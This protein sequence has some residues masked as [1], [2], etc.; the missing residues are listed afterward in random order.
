[1]NPFVS[2]AKSDYRESVRQQ[3]AL[4]TLIMGRKEFSICL[5][6]LPRDISEEAS[7]AMIIDFELRG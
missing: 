5:I 1:L 3:S 4:P 7:A 6:I 2:S